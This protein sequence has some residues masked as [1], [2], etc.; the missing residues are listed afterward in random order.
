[1]VA[2]TF[3]WRGWDDRSTWLKKQ[4]FEVCRLFRQNL[5][6]LKT[7][8]TWSCGSYK[9]CN[10]WLFFFCSQ[11]YPST[12]PSKR[13]K[14]I[15]CFWYDLYQKWPEKLRRYAPTKENLVEPYL[16][17]N[18]HQSASISIN[19][20]QSA[21]ISINEH[22]SASISSNQPQSAAISI[23]QHQLASI[24]INQQQSVSVSISQLS[25][26]INQHL[27]LNW[28]LYIQA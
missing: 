1:M 14:D 19:Q 22:Q 11:I 21:L 4:E 6:K 16:S 12:R 25:V 27:Y 3:Q 15:C 7:Q 18:Q 17:I 8:N 28:Q 26:N 13:A 5:W 2:G 10:E 24:G 20:Y 9:K 23:N